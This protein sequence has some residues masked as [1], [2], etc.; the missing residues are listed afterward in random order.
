MPS[1][2]LYLRGAARGKMNVEYGGESHMR[3]LNAAL[4]LRPGLL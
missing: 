4:A 3:Q 1:R 2:K